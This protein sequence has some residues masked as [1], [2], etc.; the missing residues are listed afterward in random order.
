MD[1][2]VVTIGQVWWLSG[3][4]EGVY[5]Q[6][7]RIY[8]VLESRGERTLIMNLES[9]LVRETDTNLM[10]SKEHGRWSRFTEMS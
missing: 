2:A 9:G 10:L 7:A 8:V 4:V 6:D 5:L 3:V 1:E